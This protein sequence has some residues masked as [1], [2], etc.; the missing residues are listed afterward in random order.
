MWDIDSPA[1]M[2]FMEDDKPLGWGARGDPHLRAL[3]RL[4]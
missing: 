3:V 2:I 4:Q 1:R